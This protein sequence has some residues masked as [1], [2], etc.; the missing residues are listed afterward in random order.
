MLHIAVA[1]GKGGTGKTTIA[2]SLAQ[3][4]P[5]GKTL[6]VDCDVEAPNA[7][8]FINP[9]FTA[10]KEVTKN[11]PVVDKSLCDYCGLCSD[12]CKFNAIS[13][14]KQSFSSNQNILVFPNLCHACGV[15]S[16][17]CPQNA[18]SEKPEKIGK[19]SKG[20]SVDGLDFA[21]G[22]LDIGAPDAAPVIHALKKWVLQ[23]NSHYDTIILDS[24]PGA[25]CSVV[26]T[27]R[28]ADFV[29][30]V[31]EPTPFGLHD[32]RIAIKLIKDLNLPAGIIVNRDG[33][34]NNDVDKLGKEEEIPILLR[35]PME[36]EIASALSTGKTLVSA[37]PKF[38]A[39]FKNI[40]QKINEIYRKANKVG[41]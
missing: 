27:I 6:L 3:V 1:S 41:K 7:H 34:G 13:V 4:L 30:L 22:E 32:L 40:F 23:G 17:I 9:I 21:N 20:S 38:Q 18:I 29:L 24:P 19:L 33:I 16:Y 36:R 25:S 26:E 37:F 39:A 15:C 5:I 8:L 2:T 35:I 10:T 28:G 12:A 31:T 14:I 11:I